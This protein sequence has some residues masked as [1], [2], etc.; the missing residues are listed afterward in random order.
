[1]GNNCAH[2]GPRRGTSCCVEHPRVYEPSL[3]ETKLSHGEYDWDKSTEDNHAV[4]HFT[5]IHADIRPLL[6]YTYHR[7]YSIERVRLQDRLIDNLC[8]PVAKTAEPDMLPW[9]IFTAGAMGAGKGYVARWMKEQGYFPLDSFVVVDPDQIRQMLPE[10][11][12]YVDKKPDRAGELTQKEA[13]CIA[14]ILGY[15]A[16]RQRLNVVFDGSLRN[17]EWYMEFFGQ[18]RVQFP[19]IRI[20]ILHITADI[21]QVLKNADDRAKE[22]GRKVP[23]HILRASALTVPLSVKALAPYA[24]F[25]CRIE[26]RAGQAPLLKREEGAPYPAKSVQMTWKT[27][28]NLWS[29]VDIDGDGELNSDELNIAIETGILTEAVV[30]SLDTNCDGHIC[31]NEFELAKVTAQKSGTKTYRL[32]AGCLVCLFELFLLRPHRLQPMRP[33]DQRLAPLRCPTLPPH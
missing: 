15:R 33:S 21:E 31:R 5:G 17:A 9:V 6:D 24:D 16:L 11:E 32:L 14:E 2:H 22:T 8:N 28:Q 19:G 26:N 29:P 3:V 27:F 7:K 1:M 4:T 10:W 12:L 23:E 20:M 18:L 13:G 25:V 30:R